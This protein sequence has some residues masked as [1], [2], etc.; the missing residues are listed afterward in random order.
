[1]REM[2]LSGKKCVQRMTSGSFSAMMRMNFVTWFI[3]M[4][5]RKRSMTLSS[6]L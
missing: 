3:V 1:M 5:S 4:L 6:R 2:T